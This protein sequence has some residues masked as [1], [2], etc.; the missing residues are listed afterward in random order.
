M[1]QQAGDTD[2][3]NLALSWLGSSTRL[4]N[5]DQGGAVAAAARASLLM[6]VP[7]IMEMHPWNFAVTR[8]SLGANNAEAAEGLEYAFSFDLPNDCLRWLPWRPG[9]PHHFEGEQEGTRILSSCSGP[10]IV[11]YISH[12]AD[13]TRWSPLFAR[14]VTAQLAYDL[15]E[16]IAAS[17][18]LRDRMAALFDDALEKARR[19][20]GLA[21]GRTDRPAPHHLSRSVAAMGRGGARDPGHWHR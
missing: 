16:P 3:A 19:S 8:S 6:Q 7:A 18:S 21:S 17:Q 4:A 13:R 5:I 2:M 11:R 20:D 9:D 10:L 12:V 15:A 14:A 1:A